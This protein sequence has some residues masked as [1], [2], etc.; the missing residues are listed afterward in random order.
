VKVVR[1]PTLERLAFFV[2]SLAGA[3]IVKDAPSAAL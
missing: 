1:G 3:A 2:N